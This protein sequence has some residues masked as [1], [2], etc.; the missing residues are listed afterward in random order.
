MPVSPRVTTVSPGPRCERM[1]DRCLEHTPC[2]HGGTCKDNGCICP[3]GYGGPYCQHGELGCG[4]VGTCGDVP[5]VPIA[6]SPAGGA[7]S[8]LD[9]DWQEGSGGSGTLPRV[10]CTR[11]PL[12]A[13]KLLL[14]MCSVVPPLPISLQTHLGSSALCSVRAPTW[15]CPATSSPVGE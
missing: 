5:P 7:L 15:P 8:E 14:G 4:D 9:Q 3:D 10:L 11:F 1:A 6:L 12:F 13:P 2:L